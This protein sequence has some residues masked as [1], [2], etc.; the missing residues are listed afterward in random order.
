MNMKK[1]GISGPNV[2][3][4]SQK[5][6]I[7]QIDTSDNLEGERWAILIPRTIKKEKIKKIFVD[8]KVT[9]DKL[10]KNKISLMYVDEVK[11]FEFERVYVL[12]EKMNENTRYVAYTRALNELIIVRA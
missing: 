5:E 12:S 7:V 1:I 6:L 2:R 3:S 9:T 8:N 11:G 10:G 4:I